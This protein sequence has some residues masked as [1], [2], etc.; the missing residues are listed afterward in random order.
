MILRVRA[1]SPFVGP[2][3]LPDRAA[4]TDWT[5]DNARPLVPGRPGPSR[6]YPIPHIRVDPAGPVSHEPGVQVKAPTS[7]GGWPSPVSAWGRGRSGPGPL[8]G[9]D[10]RADIGLARHLL[11]FS[12]PTPK[13]AERADQRR[14]AGPPP[15]RMRAVCPSGIWTTR[16]SPRSGS[17]ALIARS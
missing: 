15:I 1:A 7:K 13:T 17:S 9:A 5:L 4:R 12:R 10:P 3:S 2:P 11:A 16:G 8:L 14:P 6:P